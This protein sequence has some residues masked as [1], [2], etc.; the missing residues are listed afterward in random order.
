MTSAPA[1]AAYSSVIVLAAVAGG[2]VP[3]YFRRDRRDV[4]FLA[5][6]AGV[7]FGAAF[8]HML[9]EAFHTG[10]YGAFTLVPVGFVALFLIE[11]Y[12]LVH[13]CEEPPDC[14][15]HAHRPAFGLT[16]FLGLAVHTLFDGL[17]LA[18]AVEQGVGFS[19]FLAITA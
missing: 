16:A 4:S 12:V 8:F 2:T 11:R 1:V 18:S 7:M 14:E 15:E 6:A 5:F 19:S 3:L 10:G 17:A 13:A 9:P